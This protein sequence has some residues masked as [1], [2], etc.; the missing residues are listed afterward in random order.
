MITK[1]RIEK[2]YS[3]QDRILIGILVVF[4]FS[5]LG[6]LLVANSRLFMEISKNR[7]QYLVLDKQIKNLG[8]KN[9]ELR[10]L[11]TSAESEAQIEKL[12][13]EKALYK[14]EGEQVVVIK[15]EETETEEELPQEIGDSASVMDKLI[16]FL[17]EVFLRD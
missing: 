4:N 10:A 9:D 12:L 14:K 3:W 5:I 7:E 15:R 17:R 2:K 8:Q 6:F 13:R 11:F 16:D 1:K